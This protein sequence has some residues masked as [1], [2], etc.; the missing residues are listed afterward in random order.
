VHNA[1]RRLVVRLCQRADLVAL[2]QVDELE[3]GLLTAQTGDVDCLPSMDIVTT[4]ESRGQQRV[5][6]EDVKDG[7]LVPILL[8]L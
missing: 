6:L 5:L 7:W 3:Y 1:R 4:R 8:D 2:V